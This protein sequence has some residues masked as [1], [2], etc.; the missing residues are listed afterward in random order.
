MKLAIQKNH[1]RDQILYGSPDP[2][3]KRRPGGLYHVIEKNIPSSD[4]LHNNYYFLTNK[5]KHQT[6]KNE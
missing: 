2:G 5:N 1:L 3:K 6:E 4:W